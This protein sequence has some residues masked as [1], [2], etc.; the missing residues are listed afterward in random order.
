MLTTGALQE[1][2][3]EVKR[4]DKAER[5]L[6]RWKSRALKAEKTLSNLQE[7]WNGR[8]DQEIKAG[9]LKDP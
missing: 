9:Y 1:Y 8:N 2:D 3:R 4:A 5:G 7:K 6:K